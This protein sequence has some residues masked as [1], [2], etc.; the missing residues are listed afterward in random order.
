MI[1]VW[2][3]SVDIVWVLDLLEGGVLPVYSVPD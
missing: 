3:W 2:C 1:H